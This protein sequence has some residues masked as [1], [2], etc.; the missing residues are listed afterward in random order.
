MAILART[1]M[2]TQPTR[3]RAGIGSRRAHTR[4]APVPSAA[5]LYNERARVIH[6][7]LT[8]CQVFHETFMFTKL[9]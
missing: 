2:D 7:T 5:R 8:V 4:P 9:Y 6:H 1:G 3:K